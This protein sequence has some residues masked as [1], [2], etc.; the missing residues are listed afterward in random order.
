MKS[1]RQEFKSPTHLVIEPKSDERG[2]VTVVAAFVGGRII[3]L[4]FNAN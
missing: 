1:S 3:A 4:S 2:N